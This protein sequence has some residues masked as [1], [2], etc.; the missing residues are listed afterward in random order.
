M[1]T[2]LTFESFLV[3]EFFSIALLHLRWF[4]FRFLDIYQRGKMG[5]VTLEIDIKDETLIHKAFVEENVDFEGFVS[6]LVNSRL[7]DVKRMRHDMDLFRKYLQSHP[8]KNQPLWL[9]G[10]KLR[11][12][13]GWSYSHLLDVEDN[14]L[15]SKAHDEE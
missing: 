3:D 10:Y 5:I 14:I 8:R 9:Y 13:Y 1:A 2:S 15:A 11:K 4:C 7:Y 12:S 6:K